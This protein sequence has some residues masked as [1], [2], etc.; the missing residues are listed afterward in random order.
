MYL[1]LIAMHYRMTIHLIIGE[2][3]YFLTFHWEA[4]FSLDV[5]LSAP[6]ASDSQIIM[7]SDLL[8]LANELDV[9]IWRRLEQ[10]RSTAKI[11]YHRY[12]RT[13]LHVF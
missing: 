2:T 10:K 8:K 3:P 6:V 9:V 7:A 13:K 4:K 12:H 5:L 11:A 1:P